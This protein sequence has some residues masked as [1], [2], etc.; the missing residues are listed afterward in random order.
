MEGK[1][2]ATVTALLSDIGSTHGELLAIVE[3]VRQV[4][5]TM[6]DNVCE[7]VKYGGIMFSHTAFFCGVFTYSSHVSVEFGHGY[8]LKDTHSLL[9]G[10]GK[11][12]RHIKLYSIADIDKKQ[13][14]EYVRQAYELEL[15][16]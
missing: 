12:R 13:L 2:E 10:N 16:R 6:S 5:T 1:T 7:S 9:E 14:A 3:R 4:V 8:Q 11:Y 15:S